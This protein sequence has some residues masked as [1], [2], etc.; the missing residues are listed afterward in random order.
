MGKELGLVAHTCN[1][2][3]QEFEGGSLKVQRLPELQDSLGF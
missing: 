2:N 1:L 3:T